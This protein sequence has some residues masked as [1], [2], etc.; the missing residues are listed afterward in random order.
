M[1]DAD[2]HLTLFSSHSLALYE[3]KKKKRTWERESERESRGKKGTPWRMQK[4]NEEQWR[5]KGIWKEKKYKGGKRKE[6]R[7]GEERHRKQK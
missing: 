1:K 6:Y 4:D 5:W 3:K 2:N 7:K